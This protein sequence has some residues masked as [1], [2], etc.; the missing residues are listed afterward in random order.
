MSGNSNHISPQKHFADQIRLKAGLQ[1]GIATDRVL[2]AFFSVPREDFAGDGPW[3]LCSPL[4]YFSSP[5]VTPDADPR[6][7]YHDVLVVLDEA[8][9]INI[10][11]PSMWARFLVNVNIQP[12]E[13]ILQVGAGVGYYSAILGQLT[14]SDGRVVAYEIEA[15]LA[16]RAKSCLMKWSNVEL[17]HGNAATD[18]GIVGPFDLVIAFAGVT[19]VPDIWI[20]QLSPNARLLLPLTG[21]NGTGAMVLLQSNSE[22]FDAVTMGRCGFYHCHGARDKR[23]A[24]E[25]D[26]M[27]S[28]PGRVEGWHFRLL[29]TGSS[30]RFDYLK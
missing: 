19:H 24:A 6:W 7:L 26:E 23:L 5:V 21:V 16:K 12:G 9:G 14:G 25:I 2:S 4:S 15:E 27:F 22:G 30:I 11:Q 17:R 13:H 20:E 18:P 1:S 10:G 28:N 3:S 29:Q 8:K